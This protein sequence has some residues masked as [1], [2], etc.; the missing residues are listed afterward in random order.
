MSLCLF[1]FYV[2]TTYTAYFTL[3]WIDQTYQLAHSCFLFTVEHQHRFTNLYMTHKTL[4]GMILGQA[5]AVNRCQFNVIGSY[6]IHVPVIYTHTNVLYNKVARWLRASLQIIILQKK[7]KNTQS[8]KK[9]FVE[10]NKPRWCR[11]VCLWCSSSGRVNCIPI[12]D[13]QGQTVFKIPHKCLQ[14]YYAVA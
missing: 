5:G 12:F 10:A 4:N 9:E 8:K 14:C 3:A 1:V 13:C 11:P 6:T 7:K 2:C